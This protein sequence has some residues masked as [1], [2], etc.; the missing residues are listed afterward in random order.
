MASST[1]R[2]LNAQIVRRVLSPGCVVA[3]IGVFLVS[4]TILVLAN[5]IGSPGTLWFWRPL[6]I[7]SAIL[8]FHATVIVAA[9]RTS[10]LRAVAAWAGAAWTR[11]WLARPGW[12]R[13]G[14]LRSAARLLL[15]RCEQALA[16]PASSPVRVDQPALAPPPSTAHASAWPQPTPTSSAHGLWPA[17]VT[18][19]QPVTTWR[20]PAPA[21]AASWPTPPGSAASA[22][23]R[24]T[25]F[26]RVLGGVPVTDP[27]N[28]RWDQLEVAAT[29]W[30][31]H[32]TA[33]SAETVR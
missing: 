14:T 4:G 11:L 30:L 5:A 22:P 2:L 17:A 13:G 28:P 15:R 24:P 21:W 23:V 33:E 16:S 29:T 7:L 27:D 19:G 32:R 3:H 12:A 31:A 25:G 1:W 10:R 6:L 20:E 9:G 18:A 26:D 8:A